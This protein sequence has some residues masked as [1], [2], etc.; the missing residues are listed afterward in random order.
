MKILSIFIVSIFTLL[1]V[2]A[3]YNN[4][5]RQYSNSIVTVT[6]NN[7]NEQVLIDGRNY[8]SD[9]TNNN[10]N[11][12]YNNS[13]QITDLQPGQHTLEI[14]KGKKGILGGLFGNKNI[15]STRFNI[16]DGYDTQISVNSNDRV[17][18]RDTRSMAYQNNQNNNNKYNNQYNRNHR[19]NRNNRDRDRDNTDQ[20]N[21]R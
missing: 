14:N 19:R 17:Q 8:T 16:R 20:N 3:Q 1:T 9:N 7:T 2:S 21:N 13:F 15:S 4:N 5:G 12:G 11:R 6:L 18:V 10:G